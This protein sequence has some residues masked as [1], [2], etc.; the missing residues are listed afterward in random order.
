MKVKPTARGKTVKAAKLAKKSK[1]IKKAEKKVAKKVAAKPMK[2]T[3]TKKVAKKVAPKAKA[4]KKVAAPK[5]KAPRP[6]KERKE[7]TYG[8]YTPDELKKYKELLVEDMKLS[9]DKLK[10]ILRANMQSMTGDKKTLVE[11]VAD[12]EVLGSMPRCSKCGGGYLKWNNKK[13]QYWCNGYMDDTVW[14]FCH[15]K[16]GKGDVIRSPWTKV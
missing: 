1:G 16:G 10:A 6:K 4:V 9:N 11:K 8:G 13:G 7:A 5:V 3:K 2:A 14:K 12:G 15:F